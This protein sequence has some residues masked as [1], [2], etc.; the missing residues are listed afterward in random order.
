MW[1]ALDLRRAAI[2]L[3]LS[4][5]FT[6]SSRCSA[7]LAP[8]H[9]L[10]WCSRFATRSTHACISPKDGTRRTWT[11]GSQCMRG[12]L[13]A[14]PT[15]SHRGLHLRR[16][17]STSPKMIPHTPRTKNTNFHRRQA[18][19][20]AEVYEPR[21][22]EKSENLWNSTWQA[23]QIFVSRGHPRV[24]REFGELLAT[25][26]ISQHGRAFRRRARHG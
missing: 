11:P 2:A 4:A 24:R 20:C 19:I 3:A 15:S 9:R 8:V 12:D 23:C 21:F 10:R 14:K 16:S 6:S 5:R 7:P 13:R 17:R 22:C 18:V 26:A 25:P 1:G